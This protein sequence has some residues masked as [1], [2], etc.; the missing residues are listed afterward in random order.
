MA[1][2]SSV[3]IDRFQLAVCRSSNLTD[4]VSGG[5]IDVAF[6]QNQ[7]TMNL[8]AGTYYWAVRAIRA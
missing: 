6:G 2:S 7:H 8:T 4:C 1:R 5:Y 3:Y